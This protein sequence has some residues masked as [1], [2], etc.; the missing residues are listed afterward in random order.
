VVGQQEA[1]ATAV[2]N[3][4][5]LAVEGVMFG[6]DAG[7]QVALVQLAQAN[8]ALPLSLRCNQR[9]TGSNLK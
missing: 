5:Q 6:L 7:G 4:D 1:D 8:G 9:P 2:V 3:S